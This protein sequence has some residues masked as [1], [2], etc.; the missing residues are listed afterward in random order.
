MTA[1]ALTGTLLDAFGVSIYL[2]Y[3]FA[4]EAVKRNLVPPL[5]YWEIFKHGYIVSKFLLG[6]S[7]LLSQN[8][9]MQ[10]FACSIDTVHDDS[11]VTLVLALHACHSA[12]AAQ[13][14]LRNMLF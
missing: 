6:R 5:Q 14:K 4:R 3:K 1:D 12:E 9:R 7:H 11:H 10:I 8:S 13:L 2:Q